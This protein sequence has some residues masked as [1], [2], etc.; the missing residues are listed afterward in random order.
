VVEVTIEDGHG[1]TGHG[2]GRRSRDANLV[3][4]AP[5]DL[6]T[7]LIASPGFREEWLDGMSHE[8]ALAE[9]KES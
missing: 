2:D 7:A 3:V 8:E 9:V 6:L 4:T 1:W 5:R